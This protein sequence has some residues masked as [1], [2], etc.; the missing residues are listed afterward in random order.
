ML[1]GGWNLGDSFIG[2][3]ERDLHYATSRCKK[4]YPLPMRRNL[5]DSFIGDR[6]RDLHYATSRRKKVYPLLG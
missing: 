5:G 1:S 2:D 4:V 3:R 6:E